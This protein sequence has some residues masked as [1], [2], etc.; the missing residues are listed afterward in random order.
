MV[1]R[2][3]RGETHTLSLLTTLDIA[4]VALARVA[5]HMGPR[6]SDGENGEGRNR[7]ETNKHLVG[8]ER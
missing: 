5:S 6:R 4:G 8:G 2:L 7:Q 1:Y 3:S